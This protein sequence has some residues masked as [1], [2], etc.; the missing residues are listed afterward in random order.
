MVLSQE[1]PDSSRG[2]GEAQPLGPASTGAAPPPGPGTSDSPEAAVEKVEV[3]LAGPADVQPRESPEPP[4]GGWGWLVMLAAMWCNGSVF[5]IQNA[6]GVLFVSML[7]TF[8]SKD[9]DKMV[10]KTGQPGGPAWGPR[11]HSACEYVRL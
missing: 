4:E 9:D 5:G 10:F 8:G 3:E 11:A 7:K 2:A 1:E 6:C